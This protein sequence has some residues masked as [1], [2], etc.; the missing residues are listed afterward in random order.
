MIHIIH[1]TETSSDLWEPTTLHSCGNC[2]CILK[3]YLTYV[4]LGKRFQTNVV[5]D[6]PV[7]QYNNIITLIYI[8][9]H[10]CGPLRVAR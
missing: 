2:L 4:D 1:T 3:F 7:K 6:I 8:V 9:S 10:K 5:Y